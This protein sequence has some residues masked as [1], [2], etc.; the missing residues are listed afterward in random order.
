MRKVNKPNAEVLSDIG[1][2]MRA[3]TVQTYRFISHINLR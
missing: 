2:L 3:F 1:N